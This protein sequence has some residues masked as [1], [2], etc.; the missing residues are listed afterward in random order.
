MKQTVI[1]ICNCLHLRDS[2]GGILEYFVRRVCC[3]YFKQTVSSTLS[4]DRRG[5]GWDKSHIVNRSSWTW[6]VQIILKIEM[7]KMCYNLIKRSYKF[8]Q[9]WKKDLYSSMCSCVVCVR[10]YCKCL[11]NVSV[12]FGLFPLRNRKC[13]RS[14][15]PGQSQTVTLDPRTFKLQLPARTLIQDS[16]I[17]VRNILQRQSRNKHLLLL[18]ELLNAMWSCLESCR[19]PQIF[20]QCLNTKYKE[21]WPRV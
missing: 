1:D 5:D 9:L 4:V 18:S 20:I 21:R 13:A 15:P 17:L 3:V 10:V 11:W 6:F 19:D 8:N 12:E 7:E 14:N 2:L 16:A